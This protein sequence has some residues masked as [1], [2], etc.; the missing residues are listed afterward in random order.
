MLRHVI[1]AWTEYT[2]QRKAKIGLLWYSQGPQA[3]CGRYEN[4]QAIQSWY[5][6]HDADYLAKT[7]LL[8][9]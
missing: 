8:M 6:L 1:V 3:F 7:R 4:A 9:N 2:L 5:F